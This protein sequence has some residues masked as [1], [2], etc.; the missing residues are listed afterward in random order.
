MGLPKL[1][2]LNTRWFRTLHLAGLAVFYYVFMEWVFF[3]TKTSFM[4]PMSLVQ[5]VDTLLTAFFILS[6]PVLLLTAVL[7]AGASRFKILLWAA[8]ALPAVI[9]AAL[10][11]LLFDNFTYT[12]FKFGI[13]NSQGIWRGAYGLGFLA[14]FGWFLKDVYRRLQP[15]EAHYQGVPTYLFLLAAAASLLVTAS[16][17]GQFNFAAVR[18]DSTAAGRAALPN[19]LLLGFD[20]VNATHMSVYGYERATTPKIDALAGDALVVENAFS[21]AG[22]TGG[23][24]AAVLTSRLPTETRVVYPPDILMGEDSFQ[25]MPGLLKQMGYTTIQI[26]VPHYGDAYSM[27]LQSGFD[28]ANSRSA[29]GSALFD[30]LEKIGGGFYFVSQLLERIFER[31]AHV[32]YF[33]QMENPFLL[34]TEPASPLSEK[35]RMEEVFAYIRKTPQPLFLH[36]HMM[37]T[38]GSKFFPRESVY[39]AGQ[40]QS[41]PWMTDFY[42]DAI[43][44]A[45]KY[46]GQLFRFL[47]DRDKLDNTIVVVFSDHGSQWNPRERVPLIFWFPGGAHAGRFRENAQLID[48]APTLVDY[49]GVEQ[50][51]WMH[52]NSLLEGGLPKT[53]QL[54]SAQPASELIV[55]TDEGVSLDTTRV[56]APFYQLG[57]I[58]LI[59]CDQWFT[60]NL[61]TPGLASGTVNG[62]SASCV[63]AE[64]PSPEAAVKIM[65]DRLRQDG[66]DVSAFPADIPITSP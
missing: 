49:L 58:N 44:D 2:F 62:S 39:S 51:I 11:L 7:L 48:I 43:L 6:L 56:S 41:E 22:A 12:V 64:I 40:E 23:S 30:R 38:H 20:G 50:P 60:L 4:S 46:I 15:A 27:N 24:L 42:D 54:F 53:R 61:R 25:H 1:N 66:Y 57:R 52:G 59:V 3:A 33:Q 8:A 29:G 31:L 16:H 45:D 32:F 47:R 21:N 28:T 55:S 18:N 34:V 17:L 65:L 19:I 10:S 63:P 9:L 5:K 35:A 26:T 14:A 37:G 36:L 13:V